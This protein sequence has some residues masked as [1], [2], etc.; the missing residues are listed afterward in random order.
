L[1]IN[2]GCCNLKK[3]FYNS[4]YYNQNLGADAYESG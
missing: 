1:I 3:H 4:D 2:Y